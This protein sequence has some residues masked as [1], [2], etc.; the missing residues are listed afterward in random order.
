MALKMG[1]LRIISLLCA[2]MCGVSV[3]AQLK[4]I[5][6]ERID[7]LANPPLASNSVSMRFDHFRIEAGKMAETDPPATFEYRYVNTGESPMTIS[8]L[9]TTCSCAVAAYDRKTVAPGQEGTVTVRYNP[10][11][12]PGHFERRIFVYTDDNRQPS[13]ILR[14]SVEVTEKIN[15]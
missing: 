9:V 3:S 7:S 5:P 6:K 4:I 13:A 15:K 1:L 11:G 12:H 8:R 10:A 2:L 14:L